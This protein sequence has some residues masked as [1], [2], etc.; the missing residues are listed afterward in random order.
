[1][2]FIGV[3]VLFIFL[4]SV[5]T[6]LAW[7]R[8]RPATPNCVAVVVGGDYARS[9]RMQYHT[10]SLATTCKC[11]VHVVAYGGSS[12]PCGRVMELVRSGRVVLHLVD[13]SGGRW[14]RLFK[15][16]LWLA[17]R[18]VFVLPRCRAIVVQNPPAVP[19]LPIA[20]VA[21]AMTGASLV[22]DWHNL[23]H[24]ILAVSRCPHPVLV[25]VYRAIEILFGRGDVNLC[26][27]H[28]MERWLVQHGIRNVTV[29]HD[30]APRSVPYRR[31]A[32]ASERR[33]FLEKVFL[34][35]QRNETKVPMPKGCFTMV[36]SCSWTKDDDTDMLLDA[37]SALV[38]RNVV[39]KRRPLWLLATG[40]GETRD[41]FVAEATRRFSDLFPAVTVT[42]QFFDSYDDYATALGSADIGVCMH[43]ST[44][45]FDL[46]MKV[47]DMFGC[48]LPVVCLDYECL[49]ELV[50]HG[51]S[52][53]TFTTVDGL[54]DEIE[55]LCEEQE[56]Q[57]EVDTVDSALGRARE[58]I[59]KT[60]NE[61]WETQ[62]DRV[63]APIMRGTIK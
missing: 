62:W 56:G 37:I 29:F 30:K 63:V 43:R 55:R 17:V 8:L 25:S 9:P 13:L 10:I 24:T 35:G 21:A 46:P 20:R 26:V 51:K 34:D 16:T 3:M 38:R 22:V 39:H 2:T 41:A 7:V 36:M 4:L 5:F 52:G 48:G 31:V 27:S 40:K 57:Q 15:T 1:M 23:G 42:N 49:G 14:K 44:S 11:T 50:E 61:R 28:A 53:W 6:L 45:G 60:H 18:L 32:Q 58:Y 19:T 47:V 59:T 12:P 54:A 33:R